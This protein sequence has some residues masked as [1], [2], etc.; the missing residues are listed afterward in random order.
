MADKTTTITCDHCHEQ[1]SQEDDR[2]I[3]ALEKGFNLCSRCAQELVLNYR[4]AIDRHRN[5]NALR[6][7]KKLTPSSIKAFL[8]RYVIGQDN[9]KVILANAVYNHY[10]TIRYKQQHKDDPT[11]VELEKSN[12][13]LCGVSGI[14]KSYLIKTIAKFLSVPYTIET[15]TSLSQTGSEIRGPLWSNAI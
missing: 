7:N 11:A 12:I 5:E 2:V 15:S 6:K 1:I 8:D 14:G 3:F 13:L 9:A 10:K 4:D